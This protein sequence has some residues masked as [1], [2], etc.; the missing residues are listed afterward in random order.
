MTWSYFFV[1]S[2]DEEL[3]SGCVMVTCYLYS[4]YYWILME[5]DGSE[6]VNIAAI[7]LH[8]VIVSKMI[9]MKTLH[10]SF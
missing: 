3:E 6:L 5:S 9:L 7:R 2:L 10:R 1:E 8:S 4:V